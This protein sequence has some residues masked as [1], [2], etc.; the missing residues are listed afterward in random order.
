MV[1]LSTNYMGLSLKNPLVVGSSGL[2]NSIAE[3]KEIA[4]KGAG[5]VVLK[6]IFEEQIRHETERMVKEQGGK[7]DAMQKGFDDIMNSRSFDYDEAMNYIS[8][9]AK[10]HTL[11]DYLKFI[12]EAKKAI[13]IP[14]IASINCATTY[15]WT[16]FARRIEAAGADAIE[17][18]IYMLPTD[19]LKDSSQYESV[20]FDVAEK[21]LKQV[22]IPVALKVSYYF[23]GLAKTMIDLSNTGI[24]GL[25]LFNRPFQPDINIDNLEITASHVLSNPVEYSHTLRWM[26]ILSGK[27]GCDLIASTGI[28][29]YESAI[30]QL[31]AGA[32]AVQIAS[33]LYKQGFD[34][35]DQMLQ[36]IRKWMEKKSFEKL[37]DFRGK[38]S[39][40]NVQNPAAYERVQFMKL[41][42]KI[43]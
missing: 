20:L 15:D 7:M 21:V 6:S 35:I 19:A 30:K 18:N 10:E 34:H 27:T 1:N 23:S 2:T 24:K 12:E 17:L 39:Q 40:I 11:S 9:F 29:E 14:L 5:A 8:N 31:L 38:L 28:H 43:V 41:Y 25:V 37:D 16:Y 22:K 4:A 3:L 32:Q 26:A 33:V 42:S 36:G 13:D